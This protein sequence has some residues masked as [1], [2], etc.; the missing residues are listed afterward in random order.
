MKIDICVLTAGQR[1]DLLEKCLN[2]IRPFGQKT[3]S[4]VYVFGNGCRLENMPEF[5]TTKSVK[6]NRGY[7][8]GA[9]A[10]IGMGS[11]P[12][13]LFVSDD[14]EFTD[15]AIESAVQTM[16]SDSQIGM[17]G[18]KLLF[19]SGSRNPAGKVQ[20]VGHACDLHGNII[21]PFLGWSSDNPK[22]CYSGEVFSVTG[23]TFLTR[24]KLFRAAGGFNEAYGTGYF[25]DVELALNM[26]Q[27][28][29]KIVLD[30]NAIAYH[31]VG[32]TFEKLGGSQLRANRQ[33]F[34][35]NNA[36]RLVWDTWMRY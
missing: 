12:L 18:F 36:H 7:P 19:Q 27:R 10:V 1:P 31:Y 25:E 26:R 35:L 4:P 22:T 3:N 30:A 11:N 29:S 34:V 32:A 8:G 15:G 16:Q 13:V 9:N 2:S 21:H 6:D 5:V 14:I 23:A 33:L 17:V 28:G 20:H 24:R